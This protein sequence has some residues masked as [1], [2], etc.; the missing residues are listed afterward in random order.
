MQC[1][2]ID[3]ARAYF[4]QQLRILIETDERHASWGDS[5][6]SGFWIGSIPSS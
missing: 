5:G 1:V 6:V 4:G 2:R 3:A